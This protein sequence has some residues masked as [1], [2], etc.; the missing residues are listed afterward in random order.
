[1]NAIRQARNLAE[2]L[3][4]TVSAMAG[5]HTKEYGVALKVCGIVLLIREH[6]DAEDLYNTYVLGKHVNTK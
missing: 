5:V 2:A 6:D 4:K 3:N 1:M